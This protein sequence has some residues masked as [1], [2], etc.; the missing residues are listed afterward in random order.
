M[1]SAYSALT[2]LDE[3]PPEAVIEL[4][5]LE[6]NCAASGRSTRSP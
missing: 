5:A 6:A 1:K 4:R 3:N 2:R